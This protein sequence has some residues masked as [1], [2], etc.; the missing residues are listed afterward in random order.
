MNE[1]AP[2]SDNGTIHVDGNTL[3][4]NL[5]EFVLTLKIESRK[6]M[7]SGRLKLESGRTL[8]DL[9][10]ET[11][12]TFASDLSE[13]EFMAA[14]L[15]HI[16]REQHPDLNIRRNSWNAHVMSSAPN[17]PSFKHYTSH[18]DFFRYYGKGKY[19]LEAK[20]SINSASN[21]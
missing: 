10:L 20:W 4:L 14:D 8:F 7:S 5:G 17:H 12:R 6:P 18:R 11:A 3:T 19:T 13:K 1:T 21:H 9:V 15:Y 16:A 2:S